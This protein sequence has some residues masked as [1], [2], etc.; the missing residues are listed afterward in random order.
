MQNK[1][2]VAVAVAFAMQTYYVP[3]IAADNNDDDKD[4]PANISLLSKEERSKL[5][6]TCLAALNEKDNHWGWVAGGMA[7]LA[8]GVAIGIDNN[9]GDSHHHNSSPVPPD[10]GGDV[11]PTPPDDGGDVTPTPPDDG[12]DVTPTPPDDG[13]DVTPTPPD[14]DDD[15]D[16]SVISFSNRVTINKGADT[17]QF[18]DIKLDNGDH[19]G[20][21]TLSYAEESDQWQLTTQDGK[22][23]DVANWR[24][25]DNNAAIIEGAQAN[26]LYWKY[27]SRGYLILA[28]NNTQVIAKDGA[29]NTTDRGLN[30]NGKNKTGVIISGDSTTNTLSGDS[31]V[32]DGATGIVISGDN[33]NNTIAGQSTVNGA[34]GALIS[35]EGTDTHISGGIDVTGGGTG[36]V[37]DGDN[38]KIDNAGI[39][40]ISGKGSTGSIINGNNAHVINDGEMNVTNGGTGGKIIGDNT[41]VANKGD[42]TVSGEGSTALIIDGDD[43][44]ITSEG[45]QNITD[46]ATGIHVKGDDTNASMTGDITVDSGGTAMVID[47]NSANIDITGKS[48]I[49]GAGSTGTIING[50]KAHLTNDGEL[51]VAD[52]GTGAKITGNDTVVDNTGDMTIDGAGSMALYVD[53][54]DAL[55]ISQGN[56][57]ITQGAIGTLV[58]GD[59]ARIA[60]TGDMSVDGAGTVAVIIDGNDSSL[61]QTG[62]LLVTNGAMGI[63]TYGENN[64]TTNTGNAT[65]RDKDSIGFVVAGQQNTFN[66]KGDINVSLNGTGTLVSGDDSQVKLDGDITV[67]SEQDSSGTYRGATGISVTGNNTTTSI[68]GSITLNGNYATDDMIANSD[69]LAGINISG[70]DNQVDLTGELRIDMSDKSVTDGQ[71][72]EIVGLDVEGDNNNVNL[73]GGVTLNQYAI[74]TGDSSSITAINLNGDSNV[75]LSGHSEINIS[76]KIGGSTTLVN[77]QNGGSMVLSDNSVVDVRYTMFESYTDTANALLT[78]AGENS[79]IDNQ[80]TINADG[81]MTFI[82]VSDGAQSKNSG[83]INIIANNTVA[84]DGGRGIAMVAKDEKSVAKNAAGG[85]ITLTSSLTPFAFGGMDSYPQLWYHNTA[86]AMLAYDYGTVTNEAGATIS[87]YGAGLYGVSA[88][89]G[90]ATNAGNIYVDGFQQELDENGNIVS[91]TYWDTNHHELPS[92]GMVAGSSDSGYGDA[93]AINTGTITVHNAGYGMTAM[94]G[95]TAI[96]QGTINL[97]ADGDVGEPNQLVG[98]AALFGGV[99]VNDTTGV[100]NINADYGQAFYNDGSGYIVNNGA[101]NVDG[102]P[103]ADDDT[104]HMGTAPTD[105]EWLQTL[106]GSGD[107]I[108]KTSDTGFFT[109]ETLANYGTVTLNGDVDVNGW[110]YNESGATLTVNGN[111]NITTSSGGTENHGTLNADTITTAHSMFNEAD[112]SITTDLLTLN[113]NTTFFNDGEF[114]GSIAATSYQQEIVNTGNMTVAEDGK[115]LVSGSFYFY[116]QEGAT[117]TNSGNA[118]EGGEN[119]IINMTRTSDSISQVNSGTITATNGYSA[120][121]TANASNN[122]VWIWNTETGVINGINPDAPLINLSRGYNFGNEGTINVQ[123]DNAVAISGGTSSYEINLVNSGTINVGTEQGKADGTNGTGLIG[124]QG[125]GKATTINNTADG[126]INVYADDSYAFGGQTKAIINNGE[127]NLLCETGCGIYAPSTTGTQHNADGTADIAIPDAATAPA[128]GN[129]PTPPADPN[130][131]QMLSNYIV[132]T[133]ADGSSGTLKANNLVIG[134][135]VKVGTGFTAGTADTTVVVDNAFTG[136]NIQGAENITS[137]SVV[138]NAQ[139]STDADGNVDVTMTKNAYTSVATDN[140]VNSV[141]QALDA[142]YTNNELYNSLNVGTTTELNSALKQVSG[143]QATT[144]FR[145]A[146][147][148]SNRFNMLADTA[149][150]IKDGLAFNVVAKGDPRAELGN[151]TQYDMLA[152]RQTLDVTASQNLTLEYGIA[153]LDGSGSQ[154]AGDNGLTGGYSQFFGLKHSMTFDDG[155]AWNNALRYDAHSLDSSR[156]VSYGDVNKVA[157]SSARQQY[158]EFRSEGA[159]TFSLL[160]DALKVTPHAGVKFRHT[161]E[162]GY[163]ERSAG[164]FNLSMNAGSET[165][166]DSIVGLKLDY[167]GENGWSATA[168][169]EGG[170]N[171]SYAKSQRTASLQG[172]AGQQF[173]VDD[174]QKGGGMNGLATVGVKYSAKD[175]SLNL[176]AYQWKEDGTSDKGFM[177][178]FKKTFR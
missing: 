80:G 163:K 31:S 102:S 103:I 128:Q 77:V 74:S 75:T 159:K 133:N 87:L 104:A 25:T 105:E 50:N 38:I 97:T 14:D 36:L 53:G 18:D 94:N 2:L 137:T 35:G 70:D 52:G 99:V 6:A 11:T 96:N 115:S 76:D 69:T 155:L 86:Y 72:L 4:C 30:I 15:K 134:D 95:G 81:L 17:L 62:D 13:G 89:K 143:S 139:G 42:S 83:E 22:T 23:L 43:T 140:S 88:S 154:K 131:P 116:N 91:E 39:S 51:I 145:E 110:L 8:A 1:K 172:A 27:D 125:N 59:N 109:T 174:G 71:Y 166:V 123:G 26:G 37:I 136:S 21:A 124:I 160:G 129:V 3:A 56:Q 9:G 152:L 73:M 130:A 118:V 84:G 79:S 161:M 158:M 63:I 121:T 112:G 66:N 45:T 55:I 175:S 106:A 173:S 142:G 107:S 151:D 148:L 20:P 82:Q 67:N 33:T 64:T 16:T 176:D 10:D 100:I 68:M 7:A 5:S 46:N 108:T 78:A 98:M 24:I 164:D 120:I 19:L 144:A 135:N 141:A 93:T 47:G 168:T 111:L 132:G 149:P 41:T 165:A 90:T 85:D 61:T 127:I 117:L 162:D 57:T 126:V 157:D 44:N 122:P 60:N 29:T 147:I 171:L 138:W 150:K 153:R 177:L 156:S 146:R 32:T 40:N 169:V 92:A 12:G 167:A 101:I 178:N 54:N 119:T 58:K 49:S 114:T 48:D 113:G 170:P 28:D 34:T 65:V